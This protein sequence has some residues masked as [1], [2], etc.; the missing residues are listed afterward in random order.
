MPVNFSKSVL[1]QKPIIIITFLFLLIYLILSY[2]LNIWIDEVCTIRTISHDSLRDLLRA[3]IGFEGQPPFYFIIAFFWAK[4]SNSVLFLRLLS[5][6]FTISSGL[7]LY[8]LYKKNSVTT[9]WLILILVFANPFMIYL[10][11]E[12]RCYSL[13]VLLSL[14]LIHLFQK[15]YANQNVPILIRVIFILTSI[16]AVNTQYFIAFLLLLN[17]LYLLI[18]GYRKTF[19]TYLVDMCFVLVSIS[20]VPFFITK[21]ID[22]HLYQDVIIGLKDLLRFVPG[23]FNDYIF[24]RHLFPYKIFGYFLQTIIILAILLNL[25]FKRGIRIFISDNSYLFVQSISISLCFVIVYIKLGDEFLS[26]RHTAI[27][28]PLIFLLF[29][30]LFDYFQNRYLKEL[31]IFIV[32]SFYFICSFNY[33]KLFVKDFDVIGSIKY[34]AKNSKENQPII[35]INNQLA[36]PFLYYFNERNETYVLPFVVNDS[37]GYNYINLTKPL[38]REEIGKLSLKVSKSNSFWVLNFTKPNIYDKNFIIEMLKYNQYYLESDTIIG[39]PKKYK[40]FNDLQIRR[41]KNN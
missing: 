41:F 2:K 24:N 35:I 40:S 20:W 5:T 37:T 27:L 26:I 36:L 15:Y 13:V 12:I 34:L 28:F 11:T 30:R 1:K 33:Y 18:K 10:A 32:F 3:A 38:K 23:R 39:D 17:G 19:K 22:M 8:K 21:Q 6:L 7:L 25:F 14:L 16:A 4:I 9:D 29:L 31:L